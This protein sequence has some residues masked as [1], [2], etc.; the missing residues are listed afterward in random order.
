MQ[1][2]MSVAIGIYESNSS[3]YSF[4]RGIVKFQTLLTN[5]STDTSILSKPTIKYGNKLV[6]PKDASSGIGLI[7]TGTDAHFEFNHTTSGIYK[8]Y[9]Y[10]NVGFYWNNAGSIVIRH[11]VYMYFKN[12][13]TKTKYLNVS[14]DISKVN[15][16]S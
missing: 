14:W 9:A 7:G 2:E 15:L 12:A 16:L 3:N 1:V 11:N 5:V 4:F 10:M 8:K 6:I 13:N